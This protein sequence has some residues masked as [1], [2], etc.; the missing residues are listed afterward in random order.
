MEKTI[1]FLQTTP[2]QL[3]DAIVDRL[4]KQFKA[5]KGLL[6][7]KS[8]EEYLTRHDV[9]EMLQISLGT[10]Y[11]WVNRG[12]LKRYGLANKVYFKRSEVEAALVELK[13]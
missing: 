11:N 1:Q 3:Q 10:V 5:Y 6:S 7:S 12:I 9:A 13:S 2:E 8:K 4:S